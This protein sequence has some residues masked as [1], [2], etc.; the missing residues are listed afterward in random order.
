MKYYFILKNL[1]PWKTKLLNFILL[2]VTV[3]QCVGGFLLSFSFSSS[4]QNLVNSSLWNEVIIEERSTCLL[5]SALCFL[6]LCE[7]SLR[8][9]KHLRTCSEVGFIRQHLSHTLTYWHFTGI[10]AVNDR[11]LNICPSN[12]SSINIILSDSCVSPSFICTT[13]SEHN[14]AFLSLYLY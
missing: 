1:C 8:L 14:A 2:T 13:L 12:Q 7:A 10:E 11:Q 4:W 5:N 3:V 6:V 9:E